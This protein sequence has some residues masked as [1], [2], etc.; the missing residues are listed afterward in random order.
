MHRDD[1]GIKGWSD[2]K[3]ILEGAACFVT[4]PAAAAAAAILV[5]VFPID[6]ELG[7]LE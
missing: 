5:L 4:G 7:R 6:E 2:G 3:L 1:V